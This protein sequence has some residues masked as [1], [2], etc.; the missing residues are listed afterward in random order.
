M[1]KK[2]ISNCIAITFFLLSLFSNDAVAHN[3]IIP[4]QDASD[5]EEV[6]ITSDDIEMHAVLYRSPENS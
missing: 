5:G 1:N 3:Q 4:G 6:I 2:S